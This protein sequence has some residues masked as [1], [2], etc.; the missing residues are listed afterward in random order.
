MEWLNKA[1]QSIHKSYMETVA[2]VSGPLMESKFIKE[3]VLTPEEYIQAGDLLVSKCPTWRWGKAEEGKGVNHLPEDKQ[4][5]MTERVPC[6]GRVKELQQAHRSKEIYLDSDEERDEDVMEGWQLTHQKEEEVEEEIP[7]ILSSSDEEV[8]GMFEAGEVDQL[9]AAKNIVSLRTYD[10]YITYDVYYQTPRV[11]LFGYD[12]H[13]S[14]LE[15]KA[16]FEDISV[17]HA[18][19]T[20]TIDMFPMLSISCAYIHPCKHAHV[21]KRLIGQQV[22]HGLIPRVDHYILIFL[23]LIS[24]AIP[25]IDYDYTFAIDNK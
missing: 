6:K 5:L 16:M 23:K 19:K 22:K 17:E 9:A 20:V 24:A 2:S 10:L 7:E 25:T 3:G 14:P 21:M 15:A 1:K 12:E 8:S 11:W 4:Y 18:K 13:G